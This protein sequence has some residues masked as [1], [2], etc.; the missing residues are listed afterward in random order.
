VFYSQISVIYL[1]GDDS[2]FRY[3]TKLGKKKKNKENYYYLVRLLVMILF[4]AKQ[5]L[6]SLLEMSINELRLD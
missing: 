4:N 5:A 6:N 3:I 2:H 1:G